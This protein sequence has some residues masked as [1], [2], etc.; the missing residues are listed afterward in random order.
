MN[1]GCLVVKVA[2][3]ML[4]T[5]LRFPTASGIFLFST[6]SILVLGPTQP[7]IQWALSVFD[8][9]IKRPDRA[10]DHSPPSS[11]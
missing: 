4:D 2:D 9:R 5:G 8:L 1:Q 10:A 6:A 3:Y 11:A 7:P